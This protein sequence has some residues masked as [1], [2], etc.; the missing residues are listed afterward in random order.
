M[1]SGG[2][3]A[4]VGGTELLSFGLYNLFYNSADHISG[5]HGLIIP[6]NTNGDYDR[7]PYLLS[8]IFTKL[9]SVH[10]IA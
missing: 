10:N 1:S 2:G 7:V 3:G 6:H 9:G 5:S 4:G 8:Y